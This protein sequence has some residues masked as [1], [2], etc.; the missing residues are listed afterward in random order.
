MDDDFYIDPSD[1]NDDAQLSIIDE[2]KLKVLDKIEEYTAMV[3]ENVKLQEKG[4]YDA[5]FRVL[6]RYI[7][8]MVE[9]SAL[10]SNSDGLSD[11]EILDKIKEIENSVSDFNASALE[12]ENPE[13]E[14]EITLDDMMNACQADDSNNDD[15]S[16][17]F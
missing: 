8:D 16:L 14:S 12:D 7:S 3:K 1:F 4:D 11:D 10:E 17:D 2:E 6:S 9:L 15:G 5:N 13:N